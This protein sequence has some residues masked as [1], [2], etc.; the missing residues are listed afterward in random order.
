M[1]KWVCSVVAGDEREK[2]EVSWKPQRPEGC[3]EIEG[4]QLQMVGRTSTPAQEEQGG[5]G[6]VQ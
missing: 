1:N 2:A 5:H 3:A 6:E 4:R